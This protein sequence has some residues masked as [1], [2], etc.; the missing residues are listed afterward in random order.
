MWG[1]GRHVV[2]VGPGQIPGPVPGG[3]RRGDQGGRG[4]RFRGDGHVEVVLHGAVALI[5]GVVD[6]LSV[7]LLHGEFHGGQVPQLGVLPPEDPVI[8]SAIVRRREKIGRAKDGSLRFSR[9]L[10]RGLGYG[11]RD[12]VGGLRRAVVPGAGGES[13]RGQSQSQQKA[14][15]FFHGKDLLVIPRDCFSGSCRF[16]RPAS[17]FRPPRP[18]SPPRSSRGSSRLRRRSGAW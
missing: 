12:V 9:D 4:A 14:Q 7:Q 1:E 5:D 2:D 13:R 10:R 8:R 11:G 18:A 15:R 16:S 6:D 3:H 17:V